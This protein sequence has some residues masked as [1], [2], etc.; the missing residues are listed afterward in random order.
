MRSCET[1]PPSGGRARGVGA[2]A[3]NAAGG[4][5]QLRGV[6]I[7][8]MRHAGHV[9]RRAHRLPKLAR[10]RVAIG[11]LDRERLLEN[12][13]ERVIGRRTPNAPGVGRAIRIGGR[14]AE[15]DEVVALERRTSDEQLGHDERQREHVGPRAGRA[16]RA[17]ELLGR[18]VGRRERGDVPPG[19]GE[20]AVLGGRLHDLGDA[21]V[22][23]LH[24]H[25][26]GLGAEDEDVRRLDVAVGDAAAVHDVERRAPPARA[27]R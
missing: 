7:A 19:L 17:A 10:G 13:F 3:A 2:G 14:H 18:A 24:V 15:L 11:G 27:A 12:R 22:E 8:G 4:S 20:R 26:V 16:V 25:L 9:L 1:L 5:T 6:G 23:H 21:E